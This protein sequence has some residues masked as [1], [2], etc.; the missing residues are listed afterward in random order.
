MPLL[1]LGPLIEV[2]IQKRLNRFVV[3]VTKGTGLYRAHINN[4]GRLE[5]FLKPGTTGYCLKPEK[6]GATDFRLIA[7]ADREAAALIDTQLQMRAFEHGVRIDAFPWLRDYSGFK[8]NTPLG[9]SR[10]DCRMEGKQG[11]LY[12]EAKSAVLRE[13]AAA[14]YP[15]CPTLRGRK[16][17]RELKAQADP[18]LYSGLQEAAAAGVTLR[19]IGMCSD[20]LTGQVILYAPDLIFEWE[21]TKSY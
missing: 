17:V 20:P 13:G 12:L 18:D 5:Q 19:A 8:R 9:R 7:V 4:T 14:L 16:H 6:P 21:D 3:S 11:F 15:D 2:T 10:I 1:E